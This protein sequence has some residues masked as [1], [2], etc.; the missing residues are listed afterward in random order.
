MYSACSLGSDLTRTLGISSTGIIFSPSNDDLWAG[1]LASWCHCRSPD[2]AQPGCCLASCSGQLASPCHGAS[3]PTHRT[4]RPTAQQAVGRQPHYQ[5][6][7]QSACVAG[8]R[9]VRRLSNLGLSVWELDC[10]ASVTGDC[11]TRSQ[12][13]QVVLHVGVQLLPLLF[14]RPGMPSCRYIC[15]RLGPLG[16]LAGRPVTAKGRPQG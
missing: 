16:I 5:P 2:R 10:H 1:R 11:I 6:R 15:P 13:V 14:Q 3:L 12:C 8:S 9:L 7:P 4:A